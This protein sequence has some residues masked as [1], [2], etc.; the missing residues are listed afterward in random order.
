MCSEDRSLWWRSNGTSS[1]EGTHDSSRRATR[2]LTYKCRSVE[3]R[4]LPEFRQ[5]NIAEFIVEVLYWFG[6]PRRKMEAQK[7][8]VDMGAIECCHQWCR[9]APRGR[10]ARML[11]LRLLGGQLFGAATAPSS[12]YSTVMLETLRCTYQQLPL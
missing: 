1:F 7:I 2:N 10:V 11:L 4:R 8:G 6:A 12:R 3:E 5:K 9:E